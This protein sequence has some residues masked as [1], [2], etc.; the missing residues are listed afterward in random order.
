MTNSKWLKTNAS[1]KFS[2]VITSFDPDP[3]ELLYGTIHYTDKV[4]GNSF[5]YYMME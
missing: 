4:T 3:Y 1:G 5:Y 2:F